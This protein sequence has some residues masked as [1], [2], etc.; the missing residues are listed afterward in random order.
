LYQYELA[1]LDFEVSGEYYIDDLKEPLTNNWTTSNFYVGR[2][3]FDLIA[4]ENKKFV[5]QIEEA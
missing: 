3:N 1:I 2:K 5:T 4:P